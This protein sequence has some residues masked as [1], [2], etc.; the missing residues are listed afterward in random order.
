MSRRLALLVTASI[1]CTRPNPLF[2]LSEDPTTGSDALESSSGSGTDAGGDDPDPTTG[3]TG[4]GTCDDG[5]VHPAPE[6]ADPPC[7]ESRQ[8]LIRSG[9]ASIQRAADAVVLA[10][11][12]VVVVGSFAGEIGTAPN[13]ITTTT[14]PTVGDG[15]VLRLGPDGEQLWIRQFGGAGLQRINAVAVL[16]GDTVAVTGFFTEQLVVDPRVVAAIGAGPGFVAMVDAAGEA[17]TIH[18]IGG[19]DVEPLDVAAGPDGDVLVTGRF[20]GDLLFPGA[21]YTSAGADLFAVRFD[22][23]GGP[24]WTFASTAPGDQIA[25]AVAP[26]PTGEVLIAGE[27]RDTL[28]LGADTLIAQG[29][30]GFVARLDGAG[31]PQS[32]AAIGGPGDD[33]ARALAVASDGSFVVAG[34]HG[35][36]L[37]LGGGPLADTPGAIDGYIVAFDPAGAFRW[38]RAGIILRQDAPGLAVDPA[39]HVIASLPVTGEVIDW[40]GGPFG[41]RLGLLLVKLTADGEFIWSDQLLGFVTPSG[42]GLGVGPSG[43]F[44]V[45]GA[46]DPTLTHGTVTLQSAGQLDVFA[47]LFLP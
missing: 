5:C 44:A 16:P 46:F 2:D 9:D 20:A 31:A 39:G 42:A 3:T 12:S 47:G 7:P 19:D 6:C 34:V 17:S 24:E 29:V 36:G 21:K 35:G 30:D 10:D 26:T 18:V 32:G 38:V 40:G 28:P 14:D 25:Q 33:R 45:A 22:P 11:G 37:D 27:F 43:E 13:V 41:D 4:G 23:S 1:S 15:F 8:W